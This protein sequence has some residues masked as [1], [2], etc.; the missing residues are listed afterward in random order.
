MLDKKILIRLQVPALAEGFEVFV[1]ATLP[2][3][4]AA[5]LMADAVAS[6][7]GGSYRTSGNELLCC[8]RLNTVLHPKRTF[9]DYGICHGEQLFLL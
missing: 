7:S 2:I 4:E 8:I 5:L 6:L 3:G 9:A 1:P